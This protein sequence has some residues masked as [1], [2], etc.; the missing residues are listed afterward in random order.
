[1][2]PSEAHT[3]PDFFRA[4]AVA[5]GERPAVTKDGVVTTYREIEDR[6]TTLARGLLARGVAKGTRI[7]FVYSNSAE[8]IV[9]C[10]AIA[11]IGAVAVPLSTFYKPPEFARVIRHGDLAGII[12]TPHF[13]GQDFVHHLGLALP[14]AVTAG[15]TDGPG[16]VL[17]SAPFLRWVVFDGGETPPWAHPMDW[18]T[19]PE[20]VGTIPGAV[21]DAAEREVHR[22]EIATMIYTSGQSA[23]PKGVLHSQGGIIDKVHYLVD[24]LHHPDGAQIAATM[25]YFWVGG[26]ALQL[27]CPFEVG[28]TSVCS[29]ARTSVGDRGIIGS[30]NRDH[31]PLPNTNLRAG[32]G[33]SE[34]F[35]MYSWGYGPPLPEFP[36]C[37]PLDF[38]ETDYVVK[39]VDDD[40]K[41]VGDGET[42]QIIIRGPS[43]TKGLHK[44]D[45]TYAFDA[46]GFYRTGDE[47]LVLGDQIIML[48]RL[49]DMIKTSGANVAPAE[50]ERELVSLPGVV[51]AHVVAV[52]D[53]RRGQV[54]G[55]ALVME[56]GADRDA[57]AV[58][59]AIRARLSSYKVPRLVAF[60]D[61]LDE[62]PTTPSTKVR[63]RELGELI[64]DR[65][66]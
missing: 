43:V 29:E 40:G 4:I 46:D 1:M 11:R 36:L 12:A 58:R 6:S 48:G 21:L 54:V 53:P 44:V 9:A 27:L 13:L 45:R 64:R 20:V 24:M 42:G 2:K 19:A 31:S 5:Y 10:S 66:I 60:L 7:G 38:F 51:S 8:W 41:P 50:V 34:T 37:T 3:Y 56:A 63:K 59:E 25:P 17:P 35:A 16:L 47:G 28:G 23:D 30:V 33:M 18:L 49:G 52:P 62:V 22:D 32:L 57:D 26:Y 14:E 55:A 15:E 61:T 39:V 65:G